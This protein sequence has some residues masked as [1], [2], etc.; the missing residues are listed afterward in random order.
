[1][2]IKPIVIYDDNQDDIFL[3]ENPT[4]HAHTK[5]IEIHHQLVWNKIE[6]GFI[7]LVYCNYWFSFSN[8][9]QPHEKKGR[10]ENYK[11]FYF[12]LRK[13]GPKLPHYEEKNLKFVV[14]KK[15]VSTSW[16]IIVGILFFF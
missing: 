9:L 16:K 6:N 15:Y 1:M 5:P 10:C 14:F 4:F 2:L 8:V 11:G 12:F 13:N 3:L 7:R